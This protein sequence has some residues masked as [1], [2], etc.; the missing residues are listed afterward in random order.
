MLTSLCLVAPRPLEAKMSEYNEMGKN[1]HKTFNNIMFRHV[2]GG[3]LYVLKRISARVLGVCV[4]CSLVVLKMKKKKM[5]MRM[6]AQHGKDLI[7]LAR[8]TA[9]TFG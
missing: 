3:V 8:K 9:T 1:T 2:D 7:T 6:I 5:S 4:T